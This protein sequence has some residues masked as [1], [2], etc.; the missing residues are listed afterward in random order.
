MDTIFLRDILLN[1]RHGVGASERSRPQR[2][3]LDI[4]LSQQPV[5]WKDAISRTYNYMDAYEIARV[6][7][8]DRS[9]KLIETLA[10]HIALDILKDNKI[11]EARVSVRKL[12]ILPHGAC[13][14]TITRFRP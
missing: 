3:Q 9:Y 5:A 1:G 8:E 12:D 14:V 13:G 10:E 4:E 6:H 7:C 2:F 11:K